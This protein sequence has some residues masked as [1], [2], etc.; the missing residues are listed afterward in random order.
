MTGSLQIKNDMFYMV[1]NTKDNTGKRKQ[2]WI[3]T[4]LP[5]KGNKRK[6]E[7][8]LNLLLAELD[9]VEYIEPSKVLFC[10]FVRDWVTMN[11]S[12]LQATTYMN[13]LHMVD[14]HI[15]PHFRELELQLKNVTPDSI[16][17]YHS[18]KIGSG[19]SPNTVIKHHAVM[20]STLQYAVKTKLI[21]ENPCDFVDKPKRQKYT[22]TFYNADE[23]KQLLAI[24]KGS[25]VETPIFIA[26]YFGLRRS[27]VLGLRWSALDI[28]NG[29]MA[30]RHK[31][32]RTIENGKLINLA[33]DDLKTESSYRMLPLNDSLLEYLKVVKQGQDKNRKLCG[34]SYCNDYSDY[35]CVNDMGVLLNPDYVSSAFNKLI[36]RNGLKRIRFHDLRHSC[37]SLLLAL[38]YSMKDIQ[39]WLGHSNYQTTANLYSHVDP[40]NKKNMIQG[41]SDALIF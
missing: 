35:I 16:Q 30:V 18:A 10:D 3:S 26:A 33:T 23:I 12:N 7:K 20:R 25:T 14:K 15:D 24:A 9:N 19:L 8:K 36:S 28:S 6:A 2:K 37:A 31:V 22:A 29:L 5:V 27:E 32:V 4:N 1:L 39:E 11:Q 21:K 40:R 13:Y 38:G 41:L 34:N 17:G